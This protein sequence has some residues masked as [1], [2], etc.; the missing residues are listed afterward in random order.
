MKKLLGLLIV[1]GMVAAGCSKTA[2]PTEPTNTPKYK[3]YFGQDAANHGFVAPTG[4]QAEKY[5]NAVYNQHKD[6]FYTKTQKKE[7]DYEFDCNDIFDLLGTFGVDVPDNIR[8]LQCAGKIHA[9][10]KGTGFLDWDVVAAVAAGYGLGYQGYVGGVGG[11][12]IA[13]S[14]MR[15]MDSINLGMMFSVD[16]F[17]DSIAYVGSAQW[18]GRVAVSYGGVAFFDYPPTDHQVD[19][20]VADR[21]FGSDPAFSWDW[22]KDISFDIPAQN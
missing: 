12:N 7:F 4:V 15:S 19:M 11:L 9:Q 16:Y 3:I 20:M 2:T 18:G 21:F 22:N 17:I 8:D 6:I 14:I 5:A 13:G 1:V 10:R